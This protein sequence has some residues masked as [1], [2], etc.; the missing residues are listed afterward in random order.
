MRF[1]QPLDGCNGLVPAD[2]EEAMNWLSKALGAEVAL[3][4]GSGRQ[5]RVQWVGGSTEGR[6]GESLPII[7]PNAARAYSEG[8]VLSTKDR[9]TGDTQ[10]YL[11][12]PNWV[13]RCNVS[14]RLASEESLRQ[15]LEKALPEIAK[16][17][18]GEAVIF[19][20]NG[21]RIA[22]VNPDGSVNRQY[23]GKVSEAAR[24]SMQTFSPV[25]GRSMSM[26]GAMAVRIPIG[27]EFGLGLNN[28]LSIKQKRE[29]IN[30]IKKHKNI[31]FTMDDIIGESPAITA[32]KRAALRAACSDS[33]VLLW[34]ETGTGK[35]LFAQAIHHASARKDGPFVAL[36][37]SAVPASLIESTLFGYEKGA[38]T[39][40]K[41]EGQF[42][43]FE[44][45]NGGTLFLDEISEMELAL[46]AKLL[47]VLQEKEFMRVGGTRPV[48]VDVRI[49]ASTNRDL[50]KMVKEGKF[51]EDLYFRLNVMDIRIPPLRERVG[52][53]DLL[54]RY[55]LDKYSALM[56][57]YNCK[58]SAEAMRI[59]EDYDWPGNVRE[60]Q[61]YIERAV[62][63]LNGDTLLPEHL[64]PL[65]RRKSGKA[66]TLAEAVKE[67]ERAMIAEALA[68]HQSRKEAAAAL[69]L[70]V[71]TLWRKVR[72]LGL[73]GEP[74][75]T[76]SV[77]F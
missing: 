54:A 36:N 57:K 74:Q 31:R 77:M 50:R 37:C 66:A 68:S 35:E 18:G 61:N 2:L 34:G 20:R 70:S 67:Y 60:L 7:D 75:G 51:R 72:A 4:D 43:V 56:G 13:L 76:Q 6:E 52:D 21:K 5:V 10:V 27:T 23:L 3:F 53:V 40:A 14:R 32:A 63:W 15:A 46:Q 41:D 30:E 39:G 42:G 44:T 62:N 59:L 47:R 29:L 17:V 49:I 19:D 16:V 33:T 73:N 58:I 69:G 9:L 12:V 11:P 24:K 22:S 64:P 26:V 1:K 45:A 28:K 8:M 55:F 38:F 65:V 71:T 48:A 25:V